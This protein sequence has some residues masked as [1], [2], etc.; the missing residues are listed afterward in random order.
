MGKNEYILFQVFIAPFKCLFTILGLLAAVL[1]PD[2][3]AGWPANSNRATKFI[4]NWTKF[5]DS[6]LPI[7]IFFRT[8]ILYKISKWQGRKEQQSLLR[9]E[10]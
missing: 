8:S 4:G 2:A 3:A 7:P 5:T 10:V 6:P 1:L 9:K